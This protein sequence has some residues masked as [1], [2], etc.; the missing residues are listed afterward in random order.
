MS[1]ALP[2]LC[3]VLG[4]VGTRDAGKREVPRRCFEFTEEEFG[5]SELL[6]P[7]E[8]DVAVRTPLLVLAQQIAEALEAPVLLEER[9]S[10]RVDGMGELL[11]D[12]L[13]R[14]RGWVV[15]RTSAEEELRRRVQLK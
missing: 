10:R 13:F 7:A 2:H 12:G 15:E 6:A 8:A 1:A 5:V 4:V 9:Q 3:V 11:G 14:F